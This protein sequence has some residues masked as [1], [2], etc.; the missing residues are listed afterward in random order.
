MTRIRVTT[1]DIKD[2]ELEKVPVGRILQTIYEL[3]HLGYLWTVIQVE[4][5]TG[6]LLTENYLCK[7]QLQTCI[8]HQ[9]SS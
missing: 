4:C 7:S 2:F 8:L 1:S 9:I 3:I 6:H 5:G